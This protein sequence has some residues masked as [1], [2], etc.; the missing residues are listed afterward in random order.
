MKRVG[1]GGIRMC[2]N[3]Q[4][5]LSWT[6]AVDILVMFCSIEIYVPHIYLSLTELWGLMLFAV[7]GM[8]RWTVQ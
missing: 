2:S 8:L 3:V 5:M 1:G 6:F 7:F 4:Q